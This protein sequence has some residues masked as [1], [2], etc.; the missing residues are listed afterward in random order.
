MRQTTASLWGGVFGLDFQ[1][2]APPQSR[3]EGSRKKSGSPD[4]RSRFGLLWDEAVP[5]AWDN[6]AAFWLWKLLCLGHCGVL[7]DLSGRRIKAG[8]WRGKRFMK[9]QTFVVFKPGLPIELS[10]DGS[11]GGS[12]WDKEDGWQSRD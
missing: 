10:T 1:V 3:D 7:F 6:G 9:L 12:W 8:K 11:A 4:A 2:S 5:E